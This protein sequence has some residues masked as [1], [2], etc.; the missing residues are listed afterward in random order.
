MGMAS[1][2][3]FME[4]LLSPSSFKTWLDSAKEE[5]FELGIFSIFDRQLISF[6]L[7]KRS[8]W[9]NRLIN[10]GIC[11]EKQLSIVGH[12]KF[13]WLSNKKN[14]YREVLSAWAILKFL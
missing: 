14:S 6:I 13:D 10:E 9:S 2:A 12:P 4:R 3:F 11:D 8:L 5:A 1:R 7:D